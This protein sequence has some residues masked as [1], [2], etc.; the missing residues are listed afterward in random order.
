M[1]IQSDIKQHTTPFT[2]STLHIILISIVLSYGVWNLFEVIE[3][4]NAFAGAVLFTFSLMALGV[5]SVLWV[6]E[7]LA[8]R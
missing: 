8:Y 7:K 4:S 3:P 1:T 6:I 5:Y 2:F